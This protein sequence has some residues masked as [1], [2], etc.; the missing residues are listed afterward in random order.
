[1]A[2][3]QSTADQWLDAQRRYWDAWMDMARRG[4]EAASPA[5]RKPANPWADAVEQW[6]HTVAPST[7]RPAHNLFEQM[8]NLG[9]S[10][11]SMAETMGK[12][13][14]LDDPN[15]VVETWGRMMSDAFTQ[16]SKGFN[17]FAPQTSGFAGMSPQGMP[18]FWEM[19][20]AEMTKNLPGM[21]MPGMNMPG[22]NLS[23]MNW[24]GM[25]LPMDFWQN[26]Q[27]MQGFKMPQA[28]TGDFRAQMERMLSA[29]TLGYSR[30]SQEQYQEY[31]KLLMEYEKSSRD[32]QAGFAELGQKSMEA[33]RK[34]LE[35]K[36][37]DSGP[38]TSIRAVYNLWV[39]ACEEVYAEYALSDTYAKRYGQMVN[40]LM[41]VKKQGAALM[42]Q[43]LESLNMPTRRDLTSTQRRLHDTRSEM[44]R[45]RA[46]MQ[47]L[48]QHVADI[49]VSPDEFSDLRSEIAAL[50]KLLKDS[51]GAEVERSS[52]KIES[53]PTES[54][55][56]PAAAAPS[57][58]RAT[59][60]PAS[61]T[62]PTTT[63]RK[64][65]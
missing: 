9:K 19:P 23:G 21:N 1:M 46:E 52:I 26:M 62:S 17:P 47:E 3:L 11:F 22:M 30:E 39:D 28:G 54:P 8:V 43:W 35:T 31:V 41:A 24:P 7:P 45:L 27:G 53:A 16:S 10:Y 55:A 51:T 58:N 32:Y 37:K 5:P 13:G 25:N 61:K 2:D 29:P 49:G 48:Q 14:A 57:S 33:F 42:D 63:R 44:H 36:T 4:M 18:P 15:Q 64:K 50:R 12:G 38:L 60:K 65:T 40:D 34:L 56:K 20:F 6:W 59:A